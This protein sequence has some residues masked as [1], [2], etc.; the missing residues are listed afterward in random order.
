[1][2]LAYITAVNHNIE[3]MAVPLKE[4]IADSLPTG[5]F[6]KGAKALVPLRPLITDLASSPQSI[7]PMTK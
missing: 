4:S 3:E 5:D 1:M 7:I 2:H 6:F